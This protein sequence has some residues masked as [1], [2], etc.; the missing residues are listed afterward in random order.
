MLELLDGAV[1][2]G[3]RAGNLRAE[4]CPGTGSGGFWGAGTA[5]PRLGDAGMNSLLQDPVDQARS[6]TPQAE[7]PAR[8][9]VNNP[10]FWMLEQDFDRVLVLLRLER[11]RLFPGVGE[12]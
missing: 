6:V 4:W 9:T 8:I 12:I 10:A 7:Y 5:S 2:A 11:N 3:A 1:E